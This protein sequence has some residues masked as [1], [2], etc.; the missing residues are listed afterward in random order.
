LLLLLLLLLLTALKPGNDGST[1]CAIWCTS[2][3]GGKQ[4]SSC[5]SA[6][7]TKA[8]KAISCT[9]LSGYFK[10]FPPKCY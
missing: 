9:Q 6:Y 7:D 1:S 10:N 8:Q 4:Y 3:A 5:Q 2:Q